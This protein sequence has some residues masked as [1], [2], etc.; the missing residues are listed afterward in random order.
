M[1][2]ISEMVYYMYQLK[3]KCTCYDCLSQNL[4]TISN[5][6]ISVIYKTEQSSLS[7]YIKN[8]ITAKKVRKKDDT[9]TKISKKKIQLRKKRKE[10]N[11]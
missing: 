6:M 11:K 7:I 9:K 3:K 5:R 2:L 8:S 4:F 10:L 1:L